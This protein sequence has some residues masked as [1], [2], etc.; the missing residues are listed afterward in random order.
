M[1]ASIECNDGQKQYYH[2]LQGAMMVKN[3]NGKEGTARRAAS[4]E[5]SRGHMRS[6]EEGGTLMQGRTA[7]AYRLGAQAGDSLETAGRE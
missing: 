2:H 5:H 1:V 6:K 3:K 4:T 7:W